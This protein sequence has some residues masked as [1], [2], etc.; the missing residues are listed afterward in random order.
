MVFSNLF[1]CCFLY[2]CE[3]DFFAKTGISLCGPQPKLLN[4]YNPAFFIPE[5]KKSY[6]E[7]FKL[8]YLNP[9]ITHFS[10]FGRNPFS[11]DLRRLASNMSVS[12][13]RTGQ[14]SLHRPHKLDAKL[15]CEKSLNPFKKGVITDPMGP[16]YVVS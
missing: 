4:G 1:L 6:P 12:G 13:M 10:D 3:K 9:C 5:G 8:M 15:K 11:T 7:R 14:T 16:L 2:S